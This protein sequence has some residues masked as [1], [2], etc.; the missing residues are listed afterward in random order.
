MG[1]LL[2]FFLSS[3]CFYLLSSA[4]D[5]VLVIQKIV[6]VYGFGSLEKL[7]KVKNLISLFIK[8]WICMI[9]MCKKKKLKKVGYDQ[10][11]QK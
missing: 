3:F 4:H 6:H 11:V 9:V 5:G 2:F 1:V 8:V 7:E 10:E